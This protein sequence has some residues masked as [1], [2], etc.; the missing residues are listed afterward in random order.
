MAVGV[1]VANAILLV[2]FAERHR[3]DGAAGA[4]EAAVEGARGRLRP[5]L[6]TSLRDDRRHGADGPGLGEGGEQTAPLGRAVIGGLVAATLATLLVLPAVFALVQGRAGR[7]SASLDPDDPESRT[8]TTGLGVRQRRRRGL[9]RTP[10]S[11]ADARS[12]NATRV[13]IAGRWHWRC[14]ARG[15]RRNP[16]ERSQGRDR[17]R[18][19]RSG[20]LARRP[21]LHVGSTGPSQTMPRYVH[22]RCG[23]ESRGLSHADRP[24][25]VGLLVRAP[26]RRLRAARRGARPG[27][28][29][30]RRRPSR[31]SRP[32]S[33]S[34]RPSAGPPSEPG[35]IEAFEVTRRST[36][37]SPATSRAWP[38]TSATR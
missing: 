38:S 21:T 29:P 23:V 4:A 20:S 13:P 33:P 24:G 18:P 9:G 11:C 1:A 17:Q 10:R 8:S 35:Q 15:R 37:S 2:T 25:R 36:P 16:P 34:G 30:R 28:G 31:G 12:R 32:S 22:L 27:P 3:R 6:M 7:E 26:R 5:I 19:T 14:R